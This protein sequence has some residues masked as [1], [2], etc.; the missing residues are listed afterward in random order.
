MPKLSDVRIIRAAET[1]ACINKTGELFV[2][3]EGDVEKINTIPTALKDVSLGATLT[4][5]L[6]AS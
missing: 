1:S 6:D 5:A 2:W 3:G 4:V